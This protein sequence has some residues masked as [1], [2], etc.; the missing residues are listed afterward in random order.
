MIKG[1]DVSA[2]APQRLHPAAIVC[3]VGGSIVNQSLGCF[4][5]THANMT[6]TGTNLPRFMYSGYIQ[7][8]VI[9]EGLSLLLTVL[10]VHTLYYI[11]ILF[12]WCVILGLGTCLFRHFKESR[13]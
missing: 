12:V 7:I 9:F 13:I 1:H 3:I 11:R 8:H 4:C 5:L 2:V 6:E 10:R